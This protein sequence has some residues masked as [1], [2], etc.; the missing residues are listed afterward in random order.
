MTEDQFWSIVD[1]IGWPEV[2]YD[3]AKRRFM[4]RHGISVA[5]EFRDWLMH[6]KGRLRRAGDVQAVC[7]SW[8]DLL[9]H[10]VGL[11]EKE[12]YRTIQ[13]PQLLFE[14]EASFDYQESFAYCVPFDEDYGYLT[15]DGY[16]HFIAYA[17]EHLDE[18]A[19]TD[20]DDIP[21]RIYRRYPDVEEVCRLLI[22]KDWQAAVERY[23]DLFGPGYA[24]DWPMGCYAIPNF[25]QTL[26]RYRL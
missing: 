2:H 10:V 18:I 11:G 15:D 25:V 21:P 5:E 12:Y 4:E 24:D 16:E 8:D 23:H 14:R 20:P 9:V 1:E 19:Q 3:E 26:E 7:D 13:S 6:L 22:S 17:Q